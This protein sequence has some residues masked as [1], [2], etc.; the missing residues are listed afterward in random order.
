MFANL[1]GGSSVYNKTEVCFVLSIFVGILALLYSHFVFPPAYPSGNL[2]SNGLQIYTKEQLSHYNGNASE[3]S[4]IYLAIIGHVY[5]VTKGRA[6]YG[7]G[8]G[9]AGFAGRDGTRAYVSGN[10]TK[11]GLIENIE[12]MKDQALF[13]IWEW[14]SFYDKEEKYT[15]K[16]YVEGLYIDRDGKESPY[17]KTCKERVDLFKVKKLH[18]QDLKSGHPTCNSK[19][20][21]GKGSKVW[22]DDNRVPR[23]W[24]IDAGKDAYACHC[25]AG[26]SAVPKEGKIEEYENCPSDQSVCTFPPKD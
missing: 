7:P 14:K 4:P 13:D 26:A 10:F 12:D 6:Y 5:D 9:Y 2:L 11:E 20:E 23:K 18:Q 21:S 17:Y 19:W 24:Y 15:W 8:A 3:T 16:G 25:F 1:C 22:C